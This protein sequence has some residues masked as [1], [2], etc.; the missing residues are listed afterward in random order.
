MHVPQ[1][2]ACISDYCEHTEDTWCGPQRLD[3][4]FGQKIKYGGE[5][6]YAEQDDYQEQGKAYVCSIG[7]AY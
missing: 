7:V 4:P 1:Y 5:E 6:Y 2:V 3:R